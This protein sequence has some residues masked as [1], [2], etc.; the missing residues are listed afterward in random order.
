MLGVVSEQFP[1]G[2]A[3]TIGAIGGVGMLSAGLLGGPGIGY[4][5]DYFAS[6]ELQK[7]PEIYASN[8]SST[9]NGF[10]FFPRIQG[11]DGSKVATIQGITA[12]E[13]TPEQAKVYD[14][15]LYGGR[16]ALRY[17]AAV[18]ATMAVCYLLLILIFKARGGYKQVHIEGT[19][20]QAREVP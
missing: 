11:L 12:D 17:T 20:E 18:P 8:K 16:T 15:H 2:G 10:L 13:R 7:S 19:G 3:I 1:K 6:R 9:E 5:Q 4:K 14:A